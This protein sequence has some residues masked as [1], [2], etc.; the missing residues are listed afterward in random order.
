MT[1]EYITFMSFSGWAVSFRQLLINE[2]LCRKA[3]GSYIVQNI[4]THYR[5]SIQHHHTFDNYSSPQLKR[6]TKY[7]ISER[8]DMGASTTHI[9]QLSDDSIENR[10]GELA[11]EAFKKDVIQ[12]Q[13]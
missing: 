13:K 2:T 6:S 12:H 5:G 8:T 11:I 4:N 10:E 1:E 3:A 9:W 7:C